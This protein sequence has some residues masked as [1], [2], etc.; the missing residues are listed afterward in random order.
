MQRVGISDNLEQFDI[1]SNKSKRFLKTL[2]PTENCRICLTHYPEL[3]KEKL[4]NYGIDVAFTGHAHGGMVRVP[5]FGGLYSSGEGFLPEF[6]DGV[7]TV[8]DGAKVVISRGLGN[9]H[10]I[11]RINNQPELVVVDIC[12]Y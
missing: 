8:E 7:V 5:Y 6:T 1:T 3:F 12:W 4:L 9:S 10:K 2:E 11:P